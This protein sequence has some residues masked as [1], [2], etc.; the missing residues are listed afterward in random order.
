MIV[1]SA[2]CKALEDNINVAYVP[3]M[4]FFGCIQYLHQSHDVRSHRQSD[5]GISMSELLKKACSSH[6]RIALRRRHFFQD[7]QNVFVLIQYDTI[8]SKSLTWTRKLSVQLNL[9]HVAKN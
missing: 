2:I 7:L 3:L 5:E 1:F 9:A 8:R 6:C 4:V